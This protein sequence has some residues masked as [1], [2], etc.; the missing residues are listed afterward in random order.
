MQSLTIML[1]SKTICIY[2][3]SAISQCLE[4]SAKKTLQKNLTRAVKVND[5]YFQILLVDHQLR[6]LVF[7]ALIQQDL[8]SL[9]CLIL[10][11]LSHPLDSIEQ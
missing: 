10:C 5:L 3:S 2:P 6:A 7:A 1:C 11:C 4:N 8:P 9:S